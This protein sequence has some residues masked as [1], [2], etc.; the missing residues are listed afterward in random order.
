MDNLEAVLAICGGISILGGAGAVIWKVIRPA[1]KLTQKVNELERR[2][3]KDYEAIQS[4]LATNKAQSCALI[5]MMNHMIDGNH[6][7][8]LKETRDRLQEELIIH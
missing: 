4:I 3:D 6:V 2:T 1:F 5:A 8:K 7:E